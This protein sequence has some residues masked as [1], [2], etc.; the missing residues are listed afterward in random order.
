ML[1]R[2]GSMDHAIRQQI[3]S[4]IVERLLPALLSQLAEMIDSQ[5]DLVEFG[6]PLPVSPECVIRIFVHP[7][8]WH[9]ISWMRESLRKRVQRS[10]D[11]HARYRELAIR[12]AVDVE[13]ARTSSGPAFSVAMNPGNTTPPLSA[14]AGFDAPEAGLMTPPLPSRDGDGGARSRQSSFTT[15]LVPAPATLDTADC[16]AEPEMPTLE[17]ES[18]SGR[19]LLVPLGPKRITVGR[20]TSGDGGVDVADVSIAADET[21]S[22][23]QLSLQALGDGSG[24][25]AAR[26]VGRNAISVN[27]VSIPPVRNEVDESPLH[28]RHIRVG[29]TIC[30]GHRDPIVLR[31]GS[32]SA[33]VDAASRLR[34]VATRDWIP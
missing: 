9:L 31:I 17:L 22:R 2:N 1:F 27:G 10:V 7:D 5:R 21:T 34:G 20:S 13:V 3:P 32:A 16:R 6:D 33:K 30:L 25:V 28:D 26:N 12:F 29:D 8:T 4:D 19:R 24:M 11:A 15:T 23:I 18:S 14:P